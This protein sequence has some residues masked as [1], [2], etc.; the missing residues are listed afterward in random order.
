MP[1]LHIRLSASTRPPYP[2]N[3]R[4]RTQHPT[5]IPLPPSFPDPP[6]LRLQ[7]LDQRNSTGQRGKSTGRSG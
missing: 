2:S 5:L 4:L 1:V 3:S 6:H 7:K